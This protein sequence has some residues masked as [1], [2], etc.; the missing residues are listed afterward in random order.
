M[1]YVKITKRISLLLVLAAA[2]SGMCSCS[3]NDNKNPEESVETEFTVEYPDIEKYFQEKSSIKSVENAKDSNKSLA[4]KDAIKELASRGFTDYPV[5]SSFSISGEYYEPLEASETSDEIHPMYNTYYVNS[6][7]ELWSVF[8]VEDEVMASPVALVL[9]DDNPRQ[10]VVSERDTILSY[11]NKDN[12]FYK[13]VPNEDALEVH[14]C[15]RIDSA[16]LDS[17]TLE[18]LSNG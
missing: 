7:G 18:V 11:D 1:S 14:Y 10:I 3:C 16:Q 5:T 17:L 13:T 4:E 8:I 6:S 12:R 15:D 9:Q 2:V